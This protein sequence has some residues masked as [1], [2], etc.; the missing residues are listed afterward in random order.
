VVALKRD[1][2]LGDN[3]VRHNALIVAQFLNRHGMSGITRE[4]QVPERI[5]PLPK[6]YREEDLRRFFEACCDSERV[7]FST[8]LLT[9]LREQEVTY[10]FWSDIN[11][12]LQTVH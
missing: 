2:K 7:L 9:G 11:L 10:L 5:T 8:L 12:Q 6:E 1:H 4:L 3:T